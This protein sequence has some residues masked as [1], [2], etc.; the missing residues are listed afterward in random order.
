[1]NHYECEYNGNIRRYRAYSALSAFD[2]FERQNH[3]KVSVSLIDK[4][5]KGE[6]FAHGWAYKGY[7]ENGEWVGMRLVNDMKEV[8]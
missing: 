2:K 1:M 7:K 8:A 3:V 4:E 5:T 6:K